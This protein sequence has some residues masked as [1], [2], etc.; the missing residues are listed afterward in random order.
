MEQKRKKIVIESNES[1]TLYGGVY[2]PINNPFYETIR[3]I[4][5]LISSNIKVCEVL[6]TGE[7]VRLTLSNLDKDNQ[8]KQQKIVAPKEPEVE[9]V[10]ETEKPVQAQEFKKPVQQQNNQKK[11]NN[12]KQYQ[13]QVVEPKV[14]NIVEE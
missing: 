13:K 5:S 12:K 14:D 11:F 1:I 7:R 4:S 2:G 10:I 8:I 3:N 9:Q 6:P